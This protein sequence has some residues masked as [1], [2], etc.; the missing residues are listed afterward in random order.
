MNL[1]KLRYLPVIAGV[2]TVALI[3]TATGAGADSLVPPPPAIVAAVTGTVTVNAPCFP[4]NPAEIDAELAEF[5]AG[6]LPAIPGAVPAGALFANVA[7]AGTFIDADVDTYVG[8]V[9]VGNVQACLTGIVVNALLPPLVG[10]GQLK[11][12]AY[13]TGTAVTPNK[14]NGTLDEGAFIQAGNAAVALIDTRFDVFAGPLNTAHPVA[15][16]PTMDAL[17]VIAAVPIVPPGTTVVAG[18]VVGSGCD[19][20]HGPSVVPCPLPV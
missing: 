9:N 20:D 10:D 17:A 18:P 5:G 13:V 4:N 2:S 19:S 15:N 3:G 14:I 1:R 12:A 11:P 7:I 16:M 8:T 6:P